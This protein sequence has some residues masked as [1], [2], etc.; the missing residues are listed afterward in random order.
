MMEF[1]SQEWKDRVQELYEF[2]LYIA[3]YVAKEP[4]GKNTLLNTSIPS[5]AKITGN[6]KW[7]ALNCSPPKDAKGVAL[8]SVDLFEDVEEFTVKATEL[9]DIWHDK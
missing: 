3:H 5:R 8:I 7:D 2:P 9:R 1:G 4:D 6:I